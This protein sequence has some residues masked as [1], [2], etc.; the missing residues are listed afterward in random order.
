MI[1]LK[2]YTYLL[3]PNITLAIDVF[4]ALALAFGIY[5]YSE[6]QVDH[7]NERRIISYQLADQLRHSSDDLTRM[8]RTYVVTLDPRYKQHYQEIL[9]I[10]SGTKARPEGYFLSYWDLVLA[11][12]ISPSGSGRKIAWLDLMRENGFTED[13]LGTLTEAKANSDTLAKLE[14]EAMKLAES[15]TEANR[16]KASLSLHDEKYHQAKAQIMAPINAFHQRMEE[17]TQTAVRNAKYTALIFMVIFSTGLFAASILLWR[18]YI[19]LRH[20]LGGSAEEVR[21]HIASIGQ[22]D[23]S[24]PMPETTAT[25]DSVRAGL[26]EM[27]SQ[28]LRHQTE[29][30]LAAAAIKQ[31]QA[32]L[33]E[34]QRMA[35]IGSWQMD[36]AFNHVIWSNE[37]YRIF[38]L[39]PA[40]PAPSYEGHKKLFSENSW[41]QLNFAL[42]DTVNSGTPFEIE[43]EMIRAD[44]TQGWLHSRGEAIRDAQN[45]VISLHGIAADITERKQ[46]EAATHALRDQLLQATKMEAVGHLTAGIAHDFNNM[47]GAMMGYTEIAQ[48]VVAAGQVQ[49]VDR[50]LGE[51]LNAGQRAKELIAQMLTFSRTQTDTSKMEVPVT[52]VTPVIKE[53]VA[54]LRSSIPSSIDLN[55][56]TSDPDLKARIQP[57]NLH[58]I[59]LNLTVNARDAMGEYGRIDIKT[60]KHTVLDQLCASCQQAFS[61]NFIKISVTDTG[62]GIDGHLLQNIFTP[63]FTTKEVGKGT[64]MGLSVVHGLVHTLGGHIEVESTLKKGSKFSIWLPEAASEQATEN[65]GDIL[66]NTGGT[67]AGIRI[68]IVD[69]EISMGTILK[70]FLTMQGALTS[71]FNSPV[72]ALE[73]FEEHPDQVDIV[74]TDETMPGLTG[75]HLAELMLK[76]RPDLP[77]ILCTG[78]SE[79]ASPALAE[80][81]GL[82]GFFHKPLKLNELLSKIRLVLQP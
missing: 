82:A 47:L 4:L 13:E 37:L 41:D 40:L 74:I 68:M 61:G 60:S 43:L 5:V 75:M 76:Q 62:S 66:E 70:E 8:V 24:T 55:Y 15:G 80:K 30:N 25:K 18:A 54:M 45:N 67:L 49:N 52:L 28:L 14:L 35:H 78:Y 2:K 63:F 19:Q 9:D 29:S 39:D 32:D 72:A 22:G 16:R 38:A 51:I 36:T 6:K 1:N 26:F 42:S 50:Y 11:N 77:I 27:Q 7:A 56:Q 20:S 65:L 79:H 21:S 48:K 12:H 59:I 64:G 53:V 81:I 34:A 31:S 3:P 71:V 57:V 44:G 17:R 73:A 23:L 46:T 69:D 58:Q 33:E 10:R